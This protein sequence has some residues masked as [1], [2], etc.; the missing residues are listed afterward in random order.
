MRHKE[1]GL[2]GLPQLGALEFLAVDFERRGFVPRPRRASVFGPGQE[3][4]F[5]LVGVY[6]LRGGAGRA[7]AAYRRRGVPV[8][9]ADAPHLRRDA[10][11]WHKVVWDHQHWIPSFAC[12]GDRLE[13]VGVEIAERARGGEILV[14]GQKAGDSQHPMAERQDLARWARETIAELRRVTRRPVIWRPHPLDAF[15]VREADRYS[16]PKLESVADALSRAHAVVTYNSTAGLDALIAGVP[17]V[18]M[19]PAVY[20]ELA[21]KDVAGI[22][23]F[24]VPSVEDRRALL[25]RIAYTQWTVEECRDGAALDFL[26]AAREGNP[27]GEERNAEGG[28]LSLI[29]I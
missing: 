19:G 28:R 8:L 3:E 26:L 7:A 5:R 1:I 17:V 11:R 20:G 22:D 21:A 16:D 27:F 2:Y 13:A 4:H 12:P 23:Q 15:A 14:C 9:V 10:K 18:A 6:G 24:E 29:H 25:A